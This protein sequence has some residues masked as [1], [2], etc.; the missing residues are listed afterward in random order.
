MIDTKSW[1]F[2]PEALIVY[3]SESDS[4]EV[5][6]PNPL[7]TEHKNLEDIQLPINRTIQTL[8]V[9]VRNTKKI[10]EWHPGKDLAG[11]LFMD[12]WILN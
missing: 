12:E 5:S 7:T 4:L 3:F 11:W 8:T 1:I 10:P 2:R 9:K 6:I